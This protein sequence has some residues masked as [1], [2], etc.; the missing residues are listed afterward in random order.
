MV[1]DEG[2][3]IEA[4]LD[5]IEPCSQPYAVIAVSEKPALN[6]VV[7]AMRLGVD[8][9]L[10]WPIPQ[11]SLANTVMSACDFV[12]KRSEAEDAA[13]R[14]KMALNRLSQRERQV[15]KC[16]ADGHRNKEIAGV[17]GISPRTVEIHRSNMI[18]KL[19]AKNAMDAVRIV[20]GSGLMAAL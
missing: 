10:N 2:R 11:S 5:F 4:L 20:T 18:N 6:N 7:R 3:S 16:I 8:D 17:L 1:T 9:Y 14:A 19:Q 12:D 15:L 13:V